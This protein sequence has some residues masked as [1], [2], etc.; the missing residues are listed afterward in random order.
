MTWPT[1]SSPWSAAS[2]APR[3]RSP[4]G[5]IAATVAA[6]LDDAQAALLAEATDRRDSR[7]VDVATIAEAVEAAATG[8]ARIPWAALG[9]EGEAE[10]AQRQRH[11]ALPGDARR[12]AA[13]HRRRADGARRHRR[14]RLLIP[15]P[16]VAVVDGESASR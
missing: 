8:W 4:L 7:T 10:L 13:R 16:T 5:G 3:S 6:A 15:A 11:G 9:D 12:L 14:P 1:A 2:A